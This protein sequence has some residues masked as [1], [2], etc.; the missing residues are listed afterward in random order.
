MCPN[1][2]LNSKMGAKLG[3]SDL[4]HEEKAQWLWIILA[5]REASFVIEEFKLRHVFE[6]ITQLDVGN[7]SFELD[8]VWVALVWSI[9]GR[10]SFIGVN[11]IVEP[12]FN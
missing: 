5:F 6:G 3:L 4:L 9:F 2:I 10:E 7:R 12:Y 1:M 11:D 8:S